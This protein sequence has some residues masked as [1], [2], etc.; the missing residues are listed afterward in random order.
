VNG[1][2]TDRTSRE[3]YPRP[4]TASNKGTAQRPGSCVSML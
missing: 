4:T 3:N 2:K 1:A